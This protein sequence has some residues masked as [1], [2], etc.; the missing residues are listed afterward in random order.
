[1]PEERTDGERGFLRGFADV[2]P[3]SGAGRADVEVRIKKETAKRGRNFSSCI[4]RSGQRT[5][6]GPNSTYFS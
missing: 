5:S 6:G 3:G 2:A 4:P 1:M